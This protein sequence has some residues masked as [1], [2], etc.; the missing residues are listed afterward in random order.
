[1]YFRTLEDAYKKFLKEH[2]VDYK[3]DNNFI[4]NYNGIS[5]KNFISRQGRYN[6]RGI[7]KLYMKNYYD[8]NIVAQNLKITSF[9]NYPN[10]VSL[11]ISDNYLKELPILEKLQRLNAD[12]NNI[13]YMLSQP[14]LFYLSINNNYI[15]DL[16]I[17]PNLVYLYI[18]DNEL[19]N[20]DFIMKQPALKEYAD[21]GNRYDYEF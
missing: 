19:E 10:L 14:N 20:I 16:D 8:E 12:N 18:M 2:Q 5:R 7:Y 15:V 9:P 6:Y 21:E 13:T 11:D 4:Y 3:D 17:Q 1:M